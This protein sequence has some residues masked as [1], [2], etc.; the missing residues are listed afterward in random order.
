MIA[1]RCR[2][3][4]QPIQSLW[5]VARNGRTGLASRPLSGVFKEG[6]TPGGW[7][8]ETRKLTPGL[9]CQHCLEA[10]DTSPLPDY[11]EQDLADAGLADT[12]HVGQ[13]AGDF[14]LEAA[15]K[16]LSKS[17]SKLVVATRDREPAPAKHDARLRTDSRIH[18]DLRDALYERK[19]GG[20]ELWA[21]QAAAIDAALA[22][23]DVVIE[24]ATASGKSL[25]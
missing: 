10:G 4:R 22:G 7:V 19:L 14:Q 20:G 23:K 21:H 17:L 13:A 2:T 5:Q 24:T 15:W 18:P 9:Y 3:H 1:F 8:K 6:L 11:D 25:C 12:P 16:K